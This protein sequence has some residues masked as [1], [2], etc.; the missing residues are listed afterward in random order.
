MSTTLNGQKL[1]G[2]GVAG[3]ILLIL[4][5]VAPKVAVGTTSLILLTVTL[6]H[7]NKLNTLAAWIATTTGTSPASHSTPPGGRPI[8]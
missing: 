2:Y 8:L 7:A 5:D 6:S 3:G 4:A 1:I